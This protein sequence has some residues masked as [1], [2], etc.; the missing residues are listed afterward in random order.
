MRSWGTA[1]IDETSERRSLIA[2]HL[3]PGLGPRFIARLVRVFGSA[4][5]AWGAPE[6][7]LRAVPGVKPRLAAVI[8]RGR[9]G[10]DVDGELRRAERAGAR[11]VTWLD[12]SYP[13]RLRL[14]RDPPPVLYVR[15]TWLD[16]SVPAAA[17]VGTRRASAYGL[18]IA[19][20]L[21]QVVAGAGG[22]VI[23][24]LAR[25]ID[26]AAH[27]GALRAGGVT[28][29]VLGCGVD[30]MY[31]PEH[32][33]L[34]EAV[35]RQGAVVAELPMG[36]RPRPQQ[37][38]P[39][40]RLVSG[41]SDAVIVVEGDVDSGAMI[42]ARF[43]VSQGRP[44]FA[45]P[46]SV[47]APSS[48]GPHRLL[49]EGARILARPEDVLEVLGLSPQASRALGAPDGGTCDQVGPIEARVLAVLGEDAVHIDAI[50]ARTGC[51]AAAVAGA[52]LALEMNGLVRHLPGKHFMQARG[53]RC[54]WASGRPGQ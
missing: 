25:G 14:L 37:F 17:I 28:V 42:T 52:L 18:G 29:G 10:V 12:A 54:C 6:S 32:R 46:G 21:A 49:A 4:T 27:A 39:R 34:I 13:A 48:R 35:R 53:V 31:P 3:T 26:A 9:D 43:A 40:N 2:L 24:G 5:A 51:G 36:T 23:S 41:L 7:A 22:A 8:A 16:S 33:S 20:A 50:V 47:H 11:V 19:S 44:V 15:G 38:P 1:F 45:V 30:V